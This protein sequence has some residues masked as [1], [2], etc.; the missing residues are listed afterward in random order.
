M[1][2][3]LALWLADKLVKFLKQEA[4]HISS[5]V[6]KKYLKGEKNEKLDR[7]VRQVIRV[8]NEI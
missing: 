1:D 4:Q 8:Y 2:R 7:I 6:L 5:D 3:H